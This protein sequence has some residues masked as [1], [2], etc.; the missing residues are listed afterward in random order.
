MAHRNIPI[1]IPHMGCPNQCVFCNQRSISECRSFDRAQVRVQIEQCLATIPAT[2]DVEIAFFGGSFTGIDRDLMI[3]LLEIAQDYVRQGRVGAI[4]LSTRPDY[5]SEEILSILSRYS[6]RVIELGLQS[7]DER[8]LLASKRG[9][10]AQDSERACRMI[11]QAGFGLVGQMMI[12][13]PASTPESELATAQKICDMGAEA[14]RIYPTV[15]FYDTPLCEMVKNGS[16]VP[17]NQS[18]AVARSAAVLRIFVARGVPCIRLGLCATETLTSP[19]AVMAGPNHPALGELVWNA[20][21]YGVLRERVEQRGFCGEEIILRVPAREISRIVGQKRCNIDRLERETGTRV[22]KIVGEKELQEI[23]PEAA[24]TNKDA[25][26][27][28][29]PCI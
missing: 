29:P 19:Q 17:L 20:V 21:W 23:L 15:V 3:G 28:K 2:D 6:V 26:E 13:L 4:R 14:V 5:I 22:K 10:T 16:Y 25:Q 11:L 7:M 18:D 8:V 24:D 12:G 9:H 27:E 1:F